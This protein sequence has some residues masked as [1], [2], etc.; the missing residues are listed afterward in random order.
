MVKVVG[1][2]IEEGQLSESTLA[3]IA[4]YV[5]M[6]LYNAPKQYLIEYTIIGL[7]NGDKDEDKQEFV[8]TYN[9]ED[10]LRQTE[11]HYL[12]WGKK[13]VKINKITYLG[14]SL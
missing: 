12:S 13:G 6:A 10:W 9:I 14:G 8:T 2:E 1:R 11:H 3:S 4:E 7:G 5:K